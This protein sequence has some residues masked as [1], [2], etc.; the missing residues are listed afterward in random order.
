MHKLIYH[1][2]QIK[3]KNSKK[4]KAPNKSKFANN[5]GLASLLKIMN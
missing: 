1:V 5:L 4:I 2:E 3:Q